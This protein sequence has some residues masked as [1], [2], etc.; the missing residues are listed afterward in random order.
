MSSRTQYLVLFLIALSLVLT[1]ASHAALDP[2]LVGWW[3]LNDGEGTVAKEASG[4]GVDGTLNGGPVWSA[5]GVHGGSLVFDGVD[6][7]IFIDGAYNLPVYTITIWFR[8]D[9]PGQ[10]DLVSAYAVGVQH[11]ILLELGANGTLRY[12]HRFPLGTGGGSNFFTQDT[13]DQIDGSWNHAAMVKSADEITLYV[14]GVNVGSAP[15]N[16][17]FDPTDSFGI[18]L[19]TLDNERGLARMFNGAMDDIRVFNRDLTQQEI[20]QALEARDESSGSPAPE[21]EAIDVARASQ[22]TWESG[23]FAVSHNVYFGTS[24][25]DVD[26]ASVDDPRG[27]LV[28]A[29]QTAND[30]DPGRLDFGQTYYWRVDEVNAAPDFTV[31]KGDT[32]SFEAEPFSIPISNLTATASS[33]FGASG[34]ENT[35]NGSGLVDGLHGANAADM[36]ISGGIPATIEYAFDRAYKLHELWIWNSNQLIETFVGFG[37]KDVVIEHSLDG[38]NWTVL[39]GVGPLAQAPGTADYAHNTTIDF[40]GAVARHVRMTVNSVQ[41][42]APQASL[43]EVRFFYIPVNATRPHPETGATD[44][45]PDVTLSWGR[46]GREA[47]RHEIYVGS[48]ADSLSL[49]GSGS[50]SSL[51]TLSLDLQLGETYSWRVDEVNEA[52][53]PSLWQGPVWTFS[54]VSSIVVDD[55]ESYKDEE[56][57]EI[58]A[59]WVDGFDDPANGSLVGNGAAGTPETDIVQDGSQSMPIQYGNGGAAQSEATRTFDT[60]MDWTKHGIKA[61]TLW[62]Q[63]D[64]ANTA[65]QMFVKINGIR[66]DFDGD[67]AALQ[68]KPWH[69][70]YVDLSQVAASTLSQV[71]DLSIGFEG[72]QGTVYIDTISLSPSDRQQITPEDPGAA[73]L[74][75]HYAFEGNTSD[76]T[77]THS[78]T[79]EGIPSYVAG[80]D[81]QAIKLDGVGN[82]VSVET[83]YSLPTYTA[84]L[85]LRVEGGTGNRDVMSL[86][87]AAGGFGTL[88]EITGTGQV[89]YLHRFPLG[90]SGGNN[91]RSGPGYDDGAWFHVAAVKTDTS[92]SL[93]VNGQ[94][95]GSVD[96]DTQYETLQRITLGVLKHDNLQRYFPG[97]MDEVYLYNRALSPAEVAFLAGF[98]SP[99]DTE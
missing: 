87:D 77:G 14:N 17:V 26:N 35:I 29:G 76:T 53:D 98:T 12:L 84:A 6:D 86:Y 7:Y 75:A 90:N 66:I 31:F 43:S 56:F 70:W 83:S 54:T 22:L 85:W 51:D 42:I 3:P 9:A 30:Y 69:F 71:T 79:A 37:A 39:D 55:M 18:A 44:V 74:V 91:V 58:W 5:D 49:A 50:E 68:R 11:G 27:A 99:I 25:D 33:S 8:V 15:D 82:F 28:S 59:T 41:G 73:N 61:L 65:T 32:W 67:A 4:R 52:M 23:Q 64:A 60:S 16:S 36:W 72:G 46:D 57:L 48:D 93:F 47:D 96:D 92:M 21:D 80:M 78:L 45:A 13:F 63:G 97:E 19:G 38:E 95:V 10:Q 24:Q 34:P 88:I 81:G 94:S 20:Q 2:N 89:R 40:G 1:G 62:F